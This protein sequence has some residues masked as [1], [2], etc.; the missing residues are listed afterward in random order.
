[1]GG[2]LGLRQMAGTYFLGLHLRLRGFCSFIH[3]FA[4]TSNNPETSLFMVRNKLGLPLKGST[5]VKEQCI[6]YVVGFPQH[7]YEVWVLIQP[8][9]ATSG[10]HVPEWSFW[11]TADVCFFL[12]TAQACQF[13][14]IFNVFPKYKHKWNTTYHYFFLL[15]HWEN[16]VLV[17]CQSHQYILLHWM[18]IIFTKILIAVWVNALE[19]HNSE[20]MPDTWTM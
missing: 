6:D 2:L 20:I 15:L 3:L 4:K 11:M 14:N 18:G 9:K 17:T 19:T 10:W 7:V 5:L 1:M 12:V 16:A 8:F 13:L